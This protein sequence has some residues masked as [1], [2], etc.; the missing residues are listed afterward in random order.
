MFD[1]VEFAQDDGHIGHYDAHT[2]QQQHHVSVEWIV[3]FISETANKA[4]APKDNEVVQLHDLQFAALQYCDRD[5]KKRFTDNWLLLTKRYVLWIFSDA[6]NG[7][8][9]I[10]FVNLKLRVWG[11]NKLQTPGNYAI[12]KLS[13]LLNY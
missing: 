3:R 1:F 11:W 8:T 6:D 13:Y 12:L 4:D 2:N 7:Q 9:N 10:D 5:S